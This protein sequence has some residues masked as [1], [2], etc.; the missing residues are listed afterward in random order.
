MNNKIYHKFVFLYTNLK[1]IR[2]FETI[3]KKNIVYKLNKYFK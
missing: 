2:R 3:T 1:K